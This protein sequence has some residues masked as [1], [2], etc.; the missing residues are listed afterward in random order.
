MKKISFALLL[1]FL[2]FACKKENSV[3]GLD[4]QPEE[5]LLY[6]SFDE[7]ALV[8]IKTDY[9]TGLVSSLN[10]LGVYLLGT[11]QDPV[12]GRSDA[13]IYTNFILKDNIT[14]V[15]TGSKAQMDSVVLTLAYKTDFYGDTLDPLTVNVYKL[16]PAVN[17]SKDSVYSSGSRYKYESQDITESGNGLT[18]L[19]RPA[20]FSS[21]NGVT[22]RPQLRIKLDKTWFE[23]N[24]LL[25]DDVYLKSSSAMQQLFKGLVI[26]TASTQAF[27]PG[28]GSML[29][30]SLF[31]ANTNLTFYYHNF[32]QSNQKLVLLSGAGTGHFNSFTHD[33]G[34][35]NSQLQQQIDADTSNDFLLG[36]QNVFVQSTAG[37]GLKVKFP[38][39]TKYCDSGAIS[40]V[41][42]E[43]VLKADE[44]PQWQLENYKTPLSFG[45]KAI[46]ENGRRNDIADVGGVWVGGS[47]N[48]T[49]KEYIINLPR[50]MNQLCNKKIGNYGFFIFPSESTSR[51]FRA[52]LCGSNHPQ[53]RAKLRLYYV[54]LYKQ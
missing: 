24:L 26:T 53:H 16:H 25:K 48:S 31:D 15:N 12:F 8:E 42:A 3:L 21:V 40:V 17:L 28:Y 19:P 52:V 14:N 45:I 46:D 43:L 22:T 51:A 32:T 2:L 10:N 33:Y 29:Y 27:S 30:F 23:E 4:V 11:L 47:Y 54:K 13:S 38:D 50:H 7:S 36:Q 49:T 1:V 44:D 34:T 9:D 6:S 35:A 5:D 37:L 41:R 39:V 18:F 20:T